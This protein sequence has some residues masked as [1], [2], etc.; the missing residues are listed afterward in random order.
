[1]IGTGAYG[2]LRVV[3]QVRLEAER[4]KIQ[5]LM[6]PTIEALNESAEETNAVLHVTC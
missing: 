1:V 4:R 5:L 2:S 6:L 3:K